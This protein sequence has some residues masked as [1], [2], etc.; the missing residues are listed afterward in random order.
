MMGNVEIIRDLYEAFGRGD[1]EGVLA[2]FD[3]QIQWR[4]A[5]GSPYQPDGTAWIGDA[6]ITENG[7]AKIGTDWDGFTVCPKAFHDAGDAV[8]VEARYI[9][10]HKTTGKALNTQA[11]HV[12]KLHDGKITSFQQYV[13]TAQ[14]QDVM[15]ARTPAGERAAAA[16]A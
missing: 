10:T 8:V 14:L 2:T 1:I 7:F 4:E 9:G 15:G 12:W 16:P 11:C 3:P 5:E 6:A 13:D